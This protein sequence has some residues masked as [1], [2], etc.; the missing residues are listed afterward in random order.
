MGD[1]VVLVDPLPQPSGRGEEQLVA[2]VVAQGV[3]D[4]LEV[5][6]VQEEHDELVAVLFGLLDHVEQVSEQ[7][8]AV[9]EVGEHVVVGEVPDLGLHQSRLR[10]PDPLLGALPLGDVDDRGQ[11]ERLIVDLH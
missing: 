9:G 8:G 4:P 2:G 7:H 3:V 5:V 10:L 6:E 11:D 1:Q